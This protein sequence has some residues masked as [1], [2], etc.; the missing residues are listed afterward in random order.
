MIIEN[1]GGCKR[2]PRAP[3]TP[4]HGMSRDLDGVSD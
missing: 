1:P 2:A 3:E 4:R